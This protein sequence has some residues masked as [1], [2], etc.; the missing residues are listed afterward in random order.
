[1]FNLK[2]RFLLLISLLI[3]PFFLIAK[4]G[5]IRIEGKIKIINDD[6]F[7]VLSKENFDKMEKSIIKTTT[8]WT[9]KGHRVTFEGVKLKDILNKVGAYGK[10]LRISALNNYWVDIPITDVENYGIILANRMDGK[11][12]TIRD[13]G[14][15]F[16][17]Y[18]VDDIPNL[19]KPIYLS[20]FV[21]Q[22]NKIS[23]M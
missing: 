17:I 8:S 22:I 23:V 19:N 15:Y 1:M 11:P 18:P 9:P 2:N 4:T 5:D 13:F 10:T 12:L 3:I 7:F 16:S 21:W 6:G 20:R 14:P